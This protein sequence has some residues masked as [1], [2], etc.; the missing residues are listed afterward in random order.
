MEAA[1]EFVRL[2]L[3]GTCLALPAA[4]AHGA[5]AQ[6]ANGARVIDAPPGA[7]VLIIGSPQGSPANA[8]VLTTS[9]PGDSAV[10]RLIAQQQ[11]MMQQ[12]VADMDSP[13]P[14]LPDPSQMIRAAMEAAGD[15]GVAFT[16]IGGGHGVCGESV[17]Y[18]FN[19]T[20]TQPVVHVAR[21]GDACG[22]SAPSSTRTV[23][24]PQQSVPAPARRP[25][26]LEIGYPPHSVPVSSA[27]RT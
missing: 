15:P 9:A 25:H 12:M 5:R 24:L 11:A 21:Y 17:S 10:M 23:T 13:F 8:P 16:S 26:V 19:G 22:T 2:A 27:P 20:G 14:P 4:F 18:T 3:F 1:H 7:V 6:P